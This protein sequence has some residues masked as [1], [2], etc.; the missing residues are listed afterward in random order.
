MLGGQQADFL[1]LAAAHEQ[2]GIGRAALAAQ[3]RDGAHAGRFGQLPQLL[4]GGV[5]VGSAKVHAHQD[6]GRA[7]VGGSCGGG[8]FQEFLGFQKRQ[9][10]LASGAFAIRRSGAR[11]A[12][13]AAGG[14]AVFS[15]ATEKLTE[16]PGTM[17][18]MAC[19]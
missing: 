16:R 4:Q 2:G 9:T 5:E 14:G 18:E 6:G 12:H 8:G 1:G 13:S 3:A 11:A 17:V 7:L 19:L 15:A 10:L